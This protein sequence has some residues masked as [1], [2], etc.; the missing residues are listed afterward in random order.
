[1]VLTTNF[2]PSPSN[3]YVFRVLGSGFRV[4]FFKTHVVLTTLTTN[5][6]SSPSAA[7]ACSGFEGLRLQVAGVGCGVWGVGFRNLGSGFRTWSFRLRVE[8]VWLRSSGVS[9]KVDVR[10]PGK[11]NWGLS[12]RGW[13]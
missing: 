1:V 10:L 3:G 2:N 9:R 4:S 12:S 5:L 8:G 13:G 11:G 6:D 7:Y